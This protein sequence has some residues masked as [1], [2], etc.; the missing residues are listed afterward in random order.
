MEKPILFSGEMVR[1]IL[2]GRKTQTRRVMETPPVRVE[3]DASPSVFMYNR[4]G[5]RLREWLIFDEDTSARIEFARP[6]VDTVPTKALLR[7]TKRW[8]A[9]QSR[10]PQRWTAD[11]AVGLCPYGHPYGVRNGDPRLWVRETWR[12]HERPD[13]LD[14]ILYQAD[15][16]FQPIANTKEAAEAWVSVNSHEVPRRWRPAI[17]MPRW[18]SRINLTVEGV[19]VERL[20][21]ITEADAEAEGLKRNSDIDPMGSGL[22]SSA[23]EEFAQLWNAINGKRA[24]WASNPWVWVVSFKREA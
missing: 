5:T 19:R 9:Q 10:Y 3:A 22:Y 4:D 11:E 23:R 20:Q 8:Q 14:G 16:G 6:D 21:D 7:R 15:D 17:H 13:G 18:A 12:T 2:S 1:A 24:P